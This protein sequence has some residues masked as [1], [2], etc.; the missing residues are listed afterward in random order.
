[1]AGLFFER[2]S[3]AVGGL[4]CVA[5]EKYIG[6]IDDNGDIDVSEEASA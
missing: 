5:L 3:C 4:V 6:S 2:R 1:L